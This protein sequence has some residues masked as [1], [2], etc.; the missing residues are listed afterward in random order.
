MLVI[1]DEAMARYIFTQCLAGAPY[2]VEEAASGAEGVQRARRDHPQVIV[3][4]LLMPG[5]DGYEVLR[6][7]QA[8]PVTHGIPVIIVTSRVLTL[9][10]QTQLAGQTTAILAKGT[11]STRRSRMPWRRR[12]AAR[13]RTT[14]SGDGCRRWRRPHDAPAH[15]AGG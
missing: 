3:L 5:M 6:R 1:D 7:L 2:L 12:W 10:E 13:P 9:A 4:D 11:L 8:D 14:A 15:L